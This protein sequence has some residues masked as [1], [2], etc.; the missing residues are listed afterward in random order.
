MPPDRSILAEDAQSTVKSYFF[1]SQRSAIMMLGMPAVS[2]VAIKP[3]MPNL[4]MRTMLN[5]KPMPN[6]MRDSKR[7]NLVW[8]WLFMRF[9]MLRLP[10]TT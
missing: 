3:R 7:L 8:P 2:V 9:P 1:L 5:G 6:V 10:K 4:E